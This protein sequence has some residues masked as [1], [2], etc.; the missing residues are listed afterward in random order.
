MGTLD[1]VLNEAES[2]FGLSEGKASSLLSSLLALINEQSGGLSGLL[3]RFKRVGLG[4]TVTSWLHGDA[5]AVGPEQL[6]SALGRS[7]VEDIASKAGLS[8]SAA[9]AALGFMLPKVIQKLAPGGVPPSHLPSEFS[10]YLTGPTAAV[11]SGAR[12]AMYVTER[13][14][15]KTGFS[16]FLWPLLG[17]LAILLLGFWM[18]N[19]GGSARTAA[20][21]AEEQVQ[22]AAQKA[23]S[24]LA[25]LKPGFGA[26]ELVSALNL[27]ILNFASGSAQ[28]PADGGDFLNKA[29][30]AIKSLPAGAVL[31]VGGHTDNT[32][33]A[34][35]NLQLSQQRADAVRNYLIQQGVNPDALVAKG[36]GDSKPVASNDT[37][38]GKFRNRRIEFSVLG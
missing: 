34:A 3:D 4:D 33:D 37:E 12:Q 29:A 28:I 18:W 10:S 32:G 7:T 16:R 15:E 1:M 30:V 21:D 11:A 5:K 6:E 35:S 27:D 26:P 24:A 17:L 23:N 36:Y 13:A 19:R 14:A 22:M 8:L 25:A 20:F 31:E 2:R 9:S 38:E